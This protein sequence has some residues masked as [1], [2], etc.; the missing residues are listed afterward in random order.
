LTIWDTKLQ[1]ATVEISFVS[2]IVGVKMNS[3]R[4]F[5]ST[6]DRIFL[7]TLQGMKLLAKIDVD[8][9]LGRIV[10]S[11]NS[12]YN[13]YLLYSSS[14]KDGTLNVYDTHSL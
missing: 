14:L 12:V 10:L 11:P 3:Q 8:N 1:L 13:P 7:Y 6:K 2:K 9:H 4:I 5:A